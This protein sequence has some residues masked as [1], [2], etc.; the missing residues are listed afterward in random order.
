M[1]EFPIAD[2]MA[3]NGDREHE[4]F[5]KG[6][7]QFIS[8]LCVSQARLQRLEKHKGLQASAGLSGGVEWDRIADNQRRR[9]RT[10]GCERM[11]HLS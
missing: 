11:L 8:L 10:F 2:E 6:E 9:Q 4:V 1:P 5:G 3:V 7:Q